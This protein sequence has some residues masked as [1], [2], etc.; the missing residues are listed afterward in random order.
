MGQAPDSI[1]GAFTDAD[2]TF[3]DAVDS[4]GE[5]YALTQGTFVLLEK[6]ADRELRKSAYENLY[7]GFGAF[8]NT[9]AGL[10][11]AQN[12]QLKFS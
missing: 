5:S 2:L 11:D 6:N 1:F 12:K 8:R 10:L 9:A 7:D 4:K 3:P